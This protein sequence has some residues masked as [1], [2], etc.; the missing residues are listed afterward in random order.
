MGVG[1]VIAA[2]EAGR[3]LWDRRTECW[4]ALLAATSFPMFYYARTGN[5]DVPV[6]F[7]T[8]LELAVFAHI[9]KQGFIVRRAVWLGVWAGFA[10]ATKETSFASFLAIPL[11]I[12]SLEHGD[13]S[14]GKLRS[15]T[16]WKAL[17]A[18]LC[19]AFP[20]FGLGSGLFV[21]PNRYF[22]HI[23]FGQQRLR[24]LASGEIAFLQGYPYTWTGNVQLAQRI[25]GYL[26]DAMTLPGLLLALVGIIWA[27]RRELR[28]SAFVL[29]ALTYLLV[30][31][32][33]ARVVELRYVMP[34]AFTLAFFSAR[35]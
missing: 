5:V 21:D 4:A 9:V 35:A 6:L 13:A 14:H 2:Y 20:A 1:I 30:L 12:L 27:V 15:R 22:A 32:W 17:L 34:V 18:A 25:S 26:I 8:A 33:S 11:V 24:S 3:V 19:G 23:E 31:F 29:P 28:L 10:L 7:F 16:F